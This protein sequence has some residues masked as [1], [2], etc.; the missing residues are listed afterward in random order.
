MLPCDPHVCRMSL[1]QLYVCW[2]TWNTF[3]ETPEL[4]LHG[5]WTLP[6]CSSYET[7]APRVRRMC[8]FEL[9]ELVSASL[10]DI[11]T[12]TFQCMEQKAINV[13]VCHLTLCWNESEMHRETSPPHTHL[14]LALLT[15]SPVESLFDI[16]FSVRTV[17]SWLCW[18]RGFVMIHA[19]T[20]DCFS[21]W[22]KS[23]ESNY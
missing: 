5:D 11:C 15:R 1:G 6:A 17:V 9:A 23:N 22:N 13:Q 3:R 21:A 14:S 12:C 8:F 10:S 16:C 2:F 18:Q 19:H 4:R 20:G 7:T